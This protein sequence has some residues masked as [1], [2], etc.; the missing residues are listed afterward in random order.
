MLTDAAVARVMFMKPPSPGSAFCGSQAPDGSGHFS[1]GIFTWLVLYTL[2][3]GTPCSIAAAS[4]K[5]LNALPA[6]RLICVAR[7]ILC[8]EKFCPPY[9]ATMAPVCGTT[10]AREALG[11]EG[12][13]LPGSGRNPST[14]ARA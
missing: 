13:L 11:F 4:V 14:A 9:M 5:A 7:L 1:N 8:L 10:A 3:T 2:P 12:G 6:D